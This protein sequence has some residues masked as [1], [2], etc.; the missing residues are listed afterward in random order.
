VSVTVGEVLNGIATELDATAG[1]KV[2]KR[3]SELS[4]GVTSIDCPL[5]EVYPRRGTCD[6]G[7]NTDRTVFNAGVQQLFLYVHADL[8]ARPRSVLS[9]DMGELADMIDA[10]IDV[11]QS[12]ERPPFFGVAGIKAFSWSW[13]IAI[14]V[15][16]NSRYSG[17]RFVIV[18][19]I[20]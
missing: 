1:V 18:C 4:E 11:L 8:F 3:Y 14:H 15:R 16:G 13:E 7:G 10:I 20:F 5:I 2:V 12:Q 17:A 9:D 19:R 6:P